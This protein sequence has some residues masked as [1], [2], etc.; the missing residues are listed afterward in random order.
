MFWMFGKLTYDILIPPLGKSIY[1]LSE[2]EAA[3]YFAWYQEKI[4]ERV[5]YVSK[6]CTIELR[7]PEERL[8]C[9]PES[10]MLLWKWF[11]R[12]AKTEP[13]VHAD[14]ETGKSK[15]PD[16]LFANKRQLTLETEYI[17]RDI[18][19]YLGETFRKAIPVFSGHITQNPPETFLSIIRC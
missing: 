19:M 18:G 16:E 1:Q 17:I 10:L 12:R 13:A 7:I 14:A 6:V 15:S 4:P 11:R 2:Q 3:D 5:A 8:D 9:S